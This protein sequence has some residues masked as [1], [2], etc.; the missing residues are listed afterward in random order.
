MSEHTRNRLLSITIS[1]I[2]IVLMY[3]LISAC[4]SREVESSFLVSPEGTYPVDPAF[5]E[6]YDYMG[7]LKILGYAISP[8]FQQ[9]VRKFQYV[10]S[11]CL[12]YDANAP[13][14]ERF[15]L[16]PLGKEMNVEEPPVPDPKQEN[17]LYLNGH[18]VYA[19]F[20]PLYQ[21]LG[22]GKRVGF[23]LTEIHYNSE[24]KRYEQ[25]FENL[26]F[27]WQENDP[28]GKV[29]LLAYG[30]WKCDSYCRF[31]GISNAT[32]NFPNLLNVPGD[33]YFKQEYE[34]LGIDFAGHVLSE[35]Y[36]AIDGKW[37]QI[38]E[39]VVLVADPNQPSK[40][41]LRPIPGELGV[42]VQP[43]ITASNLKGMVFWP[44]KG[45]LGYNVP[46]PF[47]DYLNAH[48]GIKVSGEPISELFLTNDQVFRQ[49]FTNLC[50][51]YFLRTTTPESLR[52]RPANLGYAYLDT[53][54]RTLGKDNFLLAQSAHALTLQVWERY[55]VIS[56]KERQ[57]IGAGVF[58]GIKP[59][60]KVEPILVVYYPDGKEGIFIF[61][62]TGEDGITFK[63]LEPIAGQ[64][65]TLVSYK[66][67]ISTLVKE[68][69]CVKDSFVIW[70]NP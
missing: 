32:I 46:Q 64:N 67:C 65:G 7:G 53:H 14:N 34:K 49:C 39:N 20:V 17:E 5:K 8:M 12:E 42:L 52:I 60:S 3:T 68:L 19:G 1:L 36:Q 66:V 62:P 2:L 26:G 38:Y 43:P 16:S 55:P 4:T 44:V 9:G 10:E 54:Q 51:D 56:S 69:F 48:G 30:T 18:V 21:N 57:E 24:L 63:R 59:L 22:G 31:Q 6:F 29:S 15:T 70:L 27:Y 41:Y 13:Y 35:P 33:E 28:P 45:E 61:P 58:E 11:G 47:L 40:V 37:E 23:P 25:F 50:L